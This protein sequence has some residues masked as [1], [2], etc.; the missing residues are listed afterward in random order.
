MHGEATSASN[1]TEEPHTMHS[2]M[3]RVAAVALAGFGLIHLYQAPGDYDEHKWLG[4][5]FVVGGL[6][7]L[8]A[9]A[10][11][12]ARSADRIWASSAA[13]SAAFFVG[14]VLS[15][16]TGVLGVHEP[17]NWEQLGVVA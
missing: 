15:R 10:L 13:I 14:F 2:L 11:L 12:L 9:A 5:S 17:G 1:S 16:T 6:F 7:A 4:I 8:G 3:R